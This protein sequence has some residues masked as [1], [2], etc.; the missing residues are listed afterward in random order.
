MNFDIKSKTKPGVIYYM[1]FKRNLTSSKIA[2]VTLRLKL[3]TSNNL[4]GH[5]NRRATQE[6]AKELGWAIVDSTHKL[7][8][9]C[10]AAKAKQKSVVKVKGYLKWWIT[11]GFL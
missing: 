7:Y 3:G 11:R 9:S 1:L 6:A 8:P 5:Y 4:L 2:T 10:T